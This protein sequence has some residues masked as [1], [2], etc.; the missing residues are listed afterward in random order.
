MGEDTY[1]LVIGGDLHDAASGETF[2]SIDPSTGDAF[3]QVPSA[4][5]E[6]VRRAA[7]AAR[8]AFDEG[9]WPRMRGRE[10]AKHLL[11]VADQIK[12]AGKGLAETEARDSGGT[13]R[14]AR[15][16]DVAM[17]I[18]TFRVFAEI[19]SREEDE[20]P[21]PRQPISQNWIRR[22]PIGVCAGI[23]PFNFPLQMAAWKI[24]PAI[25]AGNTIILKPASYTP[26]TSLM[27]GRLCLEAGLPEGV[28][29]V[30]SGSG[31]G[32][33]EPL[34]TSPLV[35]K[36]ALT[37]STEVGSRI[38]SLAADSV[39]KVTL[40]L[41]GKSASIVTDD[42]DIDYALEGILWGVFFHQGQVCSAG[43]RVFLHRRIYDELFPALVK[44]TEDIRVGPALDPASDNGPVVSQS[45]LENVERYVGIGRDEGAEVAVGGDRAIVDGHEGGYYYQPTI[46]AG[47]NGMTV[48]QE[49]IFGPVLVVIPYDDDDEAIRLANDSIYGL[50]G[51]VWSRDVPRAVKIAE[52]L[53]TGTVWINDYHMINPRYPFGGYKRSGI[54]REHGTLGYN[55]YREVKHI[56]V[57]LAGPR[58]KHPWWD[59]LLPREGDTGEAA[60]PQAEKGR[61]P[62]G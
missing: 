10:R 7:E 43:T 8:K 35:D 14:K 22:E 6:D 51:A 57:D 19:A 59:T 25:A 4:A 31:A 30:L 29:N 44:K 58:E 42:V 26:L 52:S 48:A 27:V 61:G 3:T 23:T 9:P 40:E 15:N 53:R 56:H 1:R 18:S 2:E 28:V 16:A 41:G 46:L 62:A 55:E 32:A 24:A 20:E 60:R 49:E 38:M 45:Q 11:A 33:G 47:E 21:L 17:A 50:A 13:I 54:G 36:I 5:E 12:K 34:V 39:K 37:G